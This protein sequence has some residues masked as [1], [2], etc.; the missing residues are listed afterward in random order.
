MYPKYKRGRKYPFVSVLSRPATKPP[1]TA[2]N[3]PPLQRYYPGFHFS[4]DSTIHGMEVRTLTCLE[5]V[6]QTSG[7]VQLKFVHVDSDTYYAGTLY[8]GSW[9]S[10]DD[11]T[12]ERYIGQCR[13]LR[14]VEGKKDR[15]AFHHFDDAKVFLR[16]LYM[17]TDESLG[18]SG[19]AKDEPS[20]NAAQSVIH[21]LQKSLVD[22]GYHVDVSCI[23]RMQCYP[24]VWQ[25]QVLG[26]RIEHLRSVYDVKI[27][28]YRQKPTSN[29]KA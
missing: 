28:R 7:V 2:A 21:E 9:G 26:R 6:Q 14:V 5:A 16:T 20:L 22:M 18:L 10:H 24:S 3:P 25:N 8:P 15:P 1:Y 29:S 11:S 4:S 27:T 23:S 12:P 17:L 19:I 13:V